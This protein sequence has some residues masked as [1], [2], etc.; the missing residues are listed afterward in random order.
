MITSSVGIATLCI[1]PSVGVHEQIGPS[2]V[3]F[4]ANLQSGV[5]QAKGHWNVCLW[6]GNGTG[7][8][9]AQ[10]LWTQLPKDR[11]TSGIEPCSVNLW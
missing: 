8:I 10:T 3:R 2:R 11:S 7:P 9:V 4:R 1:H 6:F 5:V